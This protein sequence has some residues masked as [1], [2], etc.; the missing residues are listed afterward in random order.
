[1]IGKLILAAAGLVSALEY[2]DPK[3]LRD[4][5]APP[6][7]WTPVASP[8]HYTANTRVSEIVWVE[9]KGSYGPGIRIQPISP[10][11]LDMIAKE[12]LSRIPEKDR[13]FRLDRE[14]NKQVRTV[15]VGDL[16][17]GNEIASEFTNLTFRVKA[18]LKNAPSSLTVNVGGVGV[19]STAK[20]ADMKKDGD[21][22]TYSFPVAKRP[23]T[24]GSISIVVDAVTA[25]DFK[26]EITV[27]DFHFKCAK[28][29]VPFKSPAPRKFVE[30]GAVE[31]RALPVDG[32]AAKAGD[33]G[34]G[35]KTEVVK[36][37][38]G[39]ETLD[40]LRITW[41]RNGLEKRTTGVATLPFAVN[42]LDWN[43]LSFLYKVEVVGTGKYERCEGR[44]LSKIPQ[45][46]MFNK[47]IDNVGVSFASDFDCYNWNEC[48]VTRTYLSEGRLNGGEAPQGWTA[49][50]CDLVNDDPVGNKWFTLDKIT[51]YEFTLKN[52]LLMPGDKVVFTVAKPT[53]TKGLVYTGGDMKLWGEFKAWKK[54]HKVKSYDEAVKVDPMARGR[55]EK[56]V[57]L[58]RDRIANVEIVKTAAGRKNP[59]GR[60]FAANCL[61]DEL[62]RILQPLNEI[63]ILEN[64][65]T[66]NDNVKLFLGVPSDAPKPVK[67][68]VAAAQKANKGKNVT[69][70]AS[71]G[72]NFYFAGS[73]YFKTVGEEKG[74]MNGVLD[75]LEGNFGLIW[76]RDE[77]VRRN[78]KDAVYIKKIYDRELGEDVD[79]TWGA[80]WVVV[81]RIDNW[82][83]SNGT[84][85]F[86]YFNRA[87]YHGC[88][89][90]PDAFNYSSY[91]VWAANHWF[92]F[93]AGKNENEKW[94]LVKGKRLRPGCYTSTPCLINVLEDG[95]L[96]FLKDRGSIKALAHLPDNNPYYKRYN[97]DSVACWIEDT[98]NTCEC[99]K[100]QKPFRLP[101]GSLI[102]KDDPDFH[103]EATYVN[104][105]AYLQM[106]RTYFNRDSELNYLIYFYTIPVPRTPVS[107]YVRAHFCPYVRVNY[108][109]PIYA[110]VNDKFWRVIVQWGQVARSMGVSEYF[111]GGNFRPSADVQAFDIKAYTQVGVKFF[112]QE[113]ETLEGSFTEMWCANRS[114]YL[115]ECDPDNVR[116][117]YC[118]RVFGEAAEKMYTFFAK[119]RALRYTEY[120][121]TDFEETGWSELGRLAIKTPS[122]KWGCDNLAE[123]LDKLIEK[124]YKQ[125]EDDVQAHFFVGKVR[126]F[127]KWYYAN[128][129]KPKVGF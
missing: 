116:A 80:H 119:L 66:T 32:W 41:T 67:D 21:V 70:V 20:C 112:G 97:D 24:V 19:F 48:G 121:D 92:G 44:R 106:V 28:K 58:M 102:T 71:E 9:Y 95:K 14:K 33:A 36:E 128:A 111:L 55:L 87:N 49:F 35:V 125:T 109:I 94:G 5:Y 61:R 110:P 27:F 64:K 47:Y 17:L 90:G 126:A 43:T 93:G 69:I 3:Y 105:N 103:A 12:G 62:T 129:K 82:G 117:Y 34:N 108:D 118:K 23:R 83:F 31:T 65:A 42:A 38:V 124:A 46:F 16:A 122:E 114:I 74:I 18:S 40:C 123:E 45:Y 30:T 60:T 77:G 15:A 113:T 79:L 88:W 11:Y 63:R 53:L 91:R 2:E 127:W 13:A 81:P 101:D 73:P 100:C 4:W 115:G 96:A 107:R 104:A 22:V 99:Q 120:R 59:V 50:K 98:W 7:D 56:S 10:Y 1:M 68:F 39:A 57:P 89:Y 51:S 85:E 54:N 86:P 25:D 78:K 75:F 84:E 52:K 8:S 37:K 72:K 76:P 26:Q 29:Y 6:P